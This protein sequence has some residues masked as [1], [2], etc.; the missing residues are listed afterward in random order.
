MVIK[1]SMSRMHNYAVN[2]SQMITLA[3][4]QWRFEAQL[5]SNLT[6]AVQSKLNM[7]PRRSEAA[8][9]LVISLSGTSI[10]KYLK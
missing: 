7:G 2:K 6:A 10:H 5:R 4:V 3:V 8:S 1:H 9:D